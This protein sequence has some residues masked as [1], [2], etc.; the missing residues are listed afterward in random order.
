MCIRWR[1]LLHTATC[2]SAPVTY[3]VRQAQ[4]ASSIGK[5]LNLKDSMNRVFKEKDIEL[6]NPVILT[7]VYDKYSMPIAAGLL[8][9]LERNG[10]FIENM[11]WKSRGFGS[12]VETGI[13]VEF[14]TVKFIVSCSYENV[15]L[16]HVSGN[17]TRFWAICRLLC[18]TTD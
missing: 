17:K 12:L 7:A 10:A 4:L 8:T 11:S 1:S 14:E 13:E 5:E 3:G 15:Y 2:A 6:T 16:E 18:D 9:W